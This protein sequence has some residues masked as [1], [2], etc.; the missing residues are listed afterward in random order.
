MNPRMTDPP[1]ARVA[2]RDAGRF[3]SPTLTPETRP[4]TTTETK[5][6]FLRLYEGEYLTAA[7][8]LDAPP[9]ER[10]WADYYSDE[11]PERY[12]TVA[13][14]N[15]PAELAARLEAQGTGDQWFDDG[16]DALSAAAPYIDENEPT[17]RFNDDAGDLLSG[18]AT[19]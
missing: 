1:P 7:A 5:T 14:C 10:S 15:V 17:I 3:V 16:Y 18:R 6:V 19:L 2:H 13:A 8:I 4:M 11:D 9:A 12:T